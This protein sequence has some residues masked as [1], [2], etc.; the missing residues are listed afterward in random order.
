MASYDPPA[1]A[2][3]GDAVSDRAWTYDSAV[4]AAALAA[5]GE[6]DAAG[7]LL[8]RLQ[9][10]QRSDGAL[11]FSYAGPA[12]TA[13]ARCARACRRGPAW[14]RCNG[15]CR[16][17]RGATISCSAGWRAGCSAAAWPLTGLLDGGPDVSWASTEHNLEARAF[18]AGLAAT[19]DGAGAGPC[20]PGLDGLDQAG[21]QALSARLR[22]AVA[23]LDAAIDRS[24]FVTAGCTSGRA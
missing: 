8:D 12:P 14:R 13:A 19:L 1:G 21:A 4:T 20:P 16:R 7:A 3:G 23:G 18:F 24:F 17:A 2:P 15:A 22:D 9:E 5:D 10:V 11:E 6:L